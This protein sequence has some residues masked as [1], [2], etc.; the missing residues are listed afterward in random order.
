MLK[1]PFPNRVNAI[2]RLPASYNEKLRDSVIT[3]VR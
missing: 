2:D 3:C 1:L